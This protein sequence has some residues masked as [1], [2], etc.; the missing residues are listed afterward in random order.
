MTSFPERLNYAMKCAGFNQKTL[1]SLAGVSRG[2]L[3]QYLSG[4]NTPSPEKI[5]KLAA[6]LGVDVDFLFGY[7]TPSPDKIEI[8]VPLIHNV[9]IQDA[10]RCLDVPEVFVESGIEQ[11]TL[12]IGVVVHTQSGRRKFHISLQKLSEYVGVPILIEIFG[13]QPVK[14]TLGREVVY[15]R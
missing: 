3:S 12:P 1:A 10:A 13:E 7:S 4:K 5:N 14:A 15:E 2:A 8:P 11:G 6:A 9:S